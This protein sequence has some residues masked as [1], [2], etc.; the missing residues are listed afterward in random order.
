MKMIELIQAVRQAEYELHNFIEMRI[1]THWQL[2]YTQALMCRDIGNGVYRVGDT[3]Y[4]GV[5]MSY[6]M[7][8]L[9]KAGYVQQSR[10]PL[11][12]RKASLTLTLK[13]REVE[14]SVNSWIDELGLADPAVVDGIIH[15]KR[16]LEK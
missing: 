9:L 6:N 14:T 8:K 1:P 7:A 15:L 2:N 3:P 10:N 12:R 5:N 16:L 11:D 13:G 4:Y